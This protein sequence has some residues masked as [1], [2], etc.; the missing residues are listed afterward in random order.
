MMQDT[1]DRD[2]KLVIPALHVAY[3]ADT[4]AQFAPD[5][6]ADYDTAA[7]EACRLLRAWRDLRYTAY[8]FERGFVGAAALLGSVRRHLDVKRK[9]R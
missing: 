9:G 3:V 2:G 5:K 7:E 6:Y 8:C 1:Y 4:L